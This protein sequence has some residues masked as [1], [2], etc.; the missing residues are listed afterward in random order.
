[1]SIPLGIIS[2]IYWSLA[3]VH[4]SCILFTNFKLLQRELIPNILKI[5]IQFQRTFSRTFCTKIK[6]Y[7]IWL[8]VKTLQKPMLQVVEE[9]S[10]AQ[11]PPYRERCP[12]LF[13]HL[14]SSIPTSTT[15]TRCGWGEE[16]GRSRRWEDRRGAAT[17]GRARR[18]SAAWPAAADSF[19]RCRGAL[20][21]RCPTSAVR[22]A[23]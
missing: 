22:S 20:A 6:S 18:S 2:G 21:A 10:T 15:A 16:R 1:M 9:V 4:E 14:P 8:L 19:R 12:L 11:G 5:V 3:K 23:S 17:R 13:S 7:K